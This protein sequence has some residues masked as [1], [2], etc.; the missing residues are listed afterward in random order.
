MPELPEVETVCRQLTPLI[1]GEQ[2]EA[3]ALYDSK[4]KL[5]QRRLLLGRT[6]H[7]IERLG[8]QIVIHVQGADHEADSY[9]A[10][11]L[12]MSGR[13]VAIRGRIPKNE[14]V[15]YLRARLFFP[16]C[17]LHFIDPRR[18]GTITL[19]C[20]RDTLLPE[21][22]DP[23]SS[24]FTKHALAELIGS[25]KQP[26][27]HWLIRQDK[28]VGIG[29][30]YASEILFAAGIHPERPVSDLTKTEQALLF[31][32]TRKILRRA[33]KHCGTTF[34]DFQDAH[35]LTGSFQKYLRVYSREGKKCKKCKSEITRIVQQQRSTFFCPRCQS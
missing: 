20:D 11:H 27:K 21:G 18:F 17:E 7:E 5:S 1:R 13:L 29:N 28:L 25:S 16:D 34:S 6:V 26:V 12:R 33:I 15:K 31:A 2:I 35:G 9:L 24:K 22:I 30:I 32:E 19:T 8:K 3:I 23:L 4:L 14:T 10:F